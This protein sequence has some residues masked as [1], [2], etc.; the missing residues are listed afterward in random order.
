VDEQMFGLVIGETAKHLLTD[1]GHPIDSLGVGEKNSH[2]VL[3]RRR[4]RP[5]P[6]R[7]RH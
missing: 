4:Q 1:R 6:V 2:G 7:A 5:A 3:F